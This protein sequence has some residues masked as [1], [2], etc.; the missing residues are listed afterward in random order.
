MKVLKATQ[1]QYEA[2]NGYTIKASQ[3][4]FIKDKFNNWIVGKEVLTDPNFSEIHSQLTQLQEID[5]VP[6]PA[7]PIG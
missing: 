5:F 3:L 6:K 4:L 2:L 7:P 1:S